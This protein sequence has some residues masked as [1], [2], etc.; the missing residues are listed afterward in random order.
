M[1]NRRQARTRVM[2]ALYAWELSG[3]DTEEVIRTVLSSSD[4][5]GAPDAAVLAFAKSLFIRSLDHRD[6]ADEIIDRHTLNWDIERIALVDKIILRMA[7]AELMGFPDIPPKV[8][9]NE[10]IE[11]AKLF[12]TGRSGKFVNGILD[13]VL[14]ELKQ[15]DKLKKTGRGLIDIQA[16][17]NTINKDK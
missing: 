1:K 11:I 4:D 9:L 3:S 12:S 16:S 14:R 7:I 6:V 13:A 8:T 10:A 15:S 17:A 2:Q 5:G